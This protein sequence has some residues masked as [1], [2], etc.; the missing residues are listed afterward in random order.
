MPA[1]LA[2]RRNL[3]FTLYDWLRV[4]ELCERPAY[5]DHSRATFDALLDLT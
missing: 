3:D 5:A 1:P 2:S 4:D